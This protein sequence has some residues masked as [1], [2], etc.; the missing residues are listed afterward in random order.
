MRSARAM[1]ISTSLAEINV[2]P[3]IDVMLVLLV[4]F[5]VAAPMMKQ[6]FPIQ[7]PKSSKST[8]IKTQP[9]TVTVPI[10]FR[11]DNRVQ[12]NA[13]PVGLRSNVFI[14]GSGCGV[15]IAS[16]GGALTGLAARKNT[17]ITIHATIRANRTLPR[18]PSAAIMP[19]PFE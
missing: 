16:S 4:V 11:K 19:Y 6:G 15:K 18:R 13:N 5:M 9:L 7:L 10:S 17:A 12:L 8:P 2:V 14:S 1:R 3:L